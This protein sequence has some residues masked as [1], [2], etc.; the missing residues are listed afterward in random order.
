MCAGVL[1]A[2]TTK[3]QEDDNIYGNA[4]T[5]S[6]PS[7]THIFFADDSMIFCKADPKEAKTLKEI[8]PEYQRIFG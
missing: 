5:H 7:I 4:I 6:A 8:F 2:L 1:S 3:G